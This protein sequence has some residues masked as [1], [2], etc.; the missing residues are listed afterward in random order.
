ME[1]M[2]R[3]VHKRSLELLKQFMEESS[4]EE[5]KA[6]EIQA[7]EECS[8]GPSFEEYLDQIEIQYDW[9]SSPDPAQVVVASVRQTKKM[10]YAKSTKVT[11]GKRRRGP[12]EQQYVFE[13]DQEI[14]ELRN[15]AKAG[16]SF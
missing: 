1:I 7:E 3:E 16:F 5:I 11:Y 9:L 12:T 2:K 4:Q 13:T 8:E 10:V 14:L 6:L 15:P